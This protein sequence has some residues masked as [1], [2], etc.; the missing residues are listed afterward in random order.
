[1]KSLKSISGILRNVALCAI[2]PAAILFSSCSDDILNETPKSSL[3]SE[4]TLTTK[5]G[6]EAYLVGL[7][8]TAREEH[9]GDDNTFTITNFPGTD[10]AEDAG[11]EYFTYRNW[12][13]YLTPITPEVETNWNWAYS[14]MIS[15]ANTIITY[16]SKPEIGDI[17]DSEAEKNAVIAEARFF[18]AYTYNLL[19]NLYG[20]VPIVD[21]VPDQPR[22]D[23]TRSSRNEVYTFAKE[24]LEFAAQWL[25]EVVSADKDGRIVKA[26]AQH[27]LTEVYI[28]LGEYQNAINSATDVIG[29]PNYALMT[30]RFGND[31]DQPGDVFAD[32]FLTGNHNRGAGNTEAIYVWQFAENVD[33]GGGSRGGNG[34]VRNMGPFQTRISAPDGVSNIATDTLGRGVGRARG[35]LYSLYEIWNDPNDIRNSKFNFRR[36]FY[37]NNPQSVNYGQL[38][39][40]S[41]LS[42]EDTLRRLYPYPRKVEGDPWEGSN[43]S[44]RIQDD[45]YVYRLAETYLL[46]AEAY[47]RNN[48]P[49]LAAADINAIRGRANATLIGPGDVSIDYILDERA[50]ELMFETSRRRTLIRMGLLV[51]RVRS[52]ALI[53]S[54]RNTIQDYH[55]LWPIPQEA[56]DA[57]FGAELT[58][59]PG[60]N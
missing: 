51:E 36:D 52:H 60:Y 28:S 40:R 21:E 13:S 57:N 26:A 5:A 49:G 1:M 9:S 34:S 45:V 15:Q 24:D 7:V 8:R 17:W 58:Q 2:I 56:I 3:N 11:E 38:I 53:E 41:A 43:T 42:K 20:G 48:E 25:P 32:L 55:N 6:F 4:Q 12:I 37:Y 30:T 35:T 50:R 33:G 39:D 31:A 14:E 27:L 16:A 46:R 47:F 54:S 59:N 19:A 10:L 23:Y 22:Y 18:R 44:G 29:S